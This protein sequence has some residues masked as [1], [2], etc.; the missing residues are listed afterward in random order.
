MLIKGV[1]FRASLLRNSLALVV[2]WLIFYPGFFSTDS[3]SAVYRAE[4][5]DLD[6]SGSPSWAVYLRIFSLFGNA[7]SLLTLLDG[8]LL[9][10]S[11][12]CLAYSLTKARAAAISSFLFCLTPI[13]WGMGI[14]LWHDIP[15]TSGLILV[16]AF[17]VRNIRKSALVT[18]EIK[19]LLIPGSIL[20]TF[21]P[22]GIPTLIIFSIILVFLKRD[23]NVILL[24]VLSIAIAVSLTIGLSF[25]VIKQSPINTLYAQEWMRGDISCYSSLE[26]GSGFVEREIPNIANTSRWKSSEACTFISRHNLTNIEV[27]Q[28]TNYVPNGW[29]RLLLE[30]PFFVLDTH[31]KRHSYLIPIPIYGIPLTPFIHST[32]EFQDRGIEWANPQIAE[33]VRVIPRLWNALRGFFGWAGL[34]FLILLVLYFRHRII[35]TSPVIV[36]SFALIS[37]L[38]VVA[39][40]PDGR[41]ALFVLICGQLSL[42]IKC[43]EWAC[44]TPP[45]L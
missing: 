34:W 38:F 26:K 16:V 17:F 39:P 33:K 2:W 12:T 3:F 35:D 30:D 11:V 9:T 36:M 20:L 32:I 13:V 43:I 44:R 22:N 27:I 1:D 5:G 8:L 45:D 24:T 15:F 31:L 37:I 10:Y 23:R 42:V 7:I 41:Y 18:H 4:S 14:T 29:I 28:S 21:K 6:N 40:I 19:Q 25:L